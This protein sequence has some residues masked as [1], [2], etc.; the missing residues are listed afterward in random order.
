[1][2]HDQG[3]KEYKFRNRRKVIFHPNDWIAGVDYSKNDD[4]S[5]DSSGTAVTEEETDDDSDED[6]E[7]EDEDTEPEDDEFEDVDPVDQDE[8]DELTNPT[9]GSHDDEDSV[10]DTHTT[11]EATHDDDATTSTTST[12]ARRSGRT[13][14]QP[15][16]RLNV[17]STSGQTYLQKKKHMKKKTSAKKLAKLKRVTFK[18]DADAILEYCHNLIGQTHPNSDLD[19]EY[20]QEEAFI[21]A[22]YMVHFNAEIMSQGHSFTQQYMLNKGLKIFDERGAAAASKEMDQLHQRNCFTPISVKDMSPEEKRKLQEALMFLTEKR[23]KTIK[24]WMVFNGK[25]TREWYS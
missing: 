14:Q 7:D 8:V 13:T 6:Y 12:E 22:Q 3:I 24:G 18:E 23:N 25:P 16:E 10:D 2:A 5:N 15:Q 19:R 17:A 1:M 4:D 11:A 21:L 20:T 9:V